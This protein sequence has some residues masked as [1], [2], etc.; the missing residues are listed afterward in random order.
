M[1]ENITSLEKSE[2]ISIIGGYVTS[3]VMKQL[4]S[5]QEVF[6]TEIVKNRINT[7]AVSEIIFLVKIFSQAESASAEFYAIMDKH[8]GLHLSEGS[9]IDPSYIF[10]LLKSFFD[11]GYARAKLFVKLQKVVLT[12]LPSINANEICAILRLYSEME[13]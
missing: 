8:I 1:K 7:L 13:V 3:G 9:Q 10:C 12:S 6:E 11:S 4:P 2:L 5:L